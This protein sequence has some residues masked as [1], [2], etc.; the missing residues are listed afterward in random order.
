MPRLRLPLCLI[1]LTM[2][3][4]LAGVASAGPASWRTGEPTCQV[5]PANNPWNTDVSKYPLHPRSNAYIDAI[6]RTEHLH[7][8]FGTVWE[9]APIGIPYAI[10]GAGQPKVTVSFYYGD[11]SDPGPYPIPPDVP[12]EGG[13]NS[14]GDR[15]VIVV[16]EAA[17]K[18]YEM[19]DAQPLNGGQSWQGGSGAVFNLNSNAL[20]PDFWTSADAAGLPIFAGLVRYSEVVQQGAINHALRFTVSQTRRA[21]IHPL[22]PPGPL[23]LRRDFPRPRST[24]P[25]A[26][27]QLLQASLSPVMRFQ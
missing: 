19:F 20:R 17:C 22:H 2:L 10:V 8:D 15:H 16:D 12:I 6:G 18:L 5:L 9:G 24:H 3:A 25:K 26:L 11:E 21:F 4:A 1:A 27:R 13:A 14:D 7:P 23:P